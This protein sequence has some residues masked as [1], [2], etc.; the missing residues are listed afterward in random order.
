LPPPGP[1]PPPAAGENSH[2]DSG[3]TSPRHMV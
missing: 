3:L 2:L 1:L